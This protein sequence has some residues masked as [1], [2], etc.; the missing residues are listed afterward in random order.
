[1]RCNL[2]LRRL[3]KLRHGSLGNAKIDGDAPAAIVAAY[4]AAHAVEIKPPAAAAT[5]GF[6]YTDF[7]PAG[8]VASRTVVPDLDLTMVTF[9]N[10]VRVNLKKTPFEANQIRISVRVGA[11]QLLEPKS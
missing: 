2:R 9:A 8:T 6:A 4:N 7:G 1:M 3:H 11:G 5:D 10:G